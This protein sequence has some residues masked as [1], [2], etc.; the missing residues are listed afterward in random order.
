VEVF[1]VGFDSKLI[2]G[3]NK[4]RKFIMSFLEKVVVVWELAE[5]REQF[6]KPEEGERQ[7]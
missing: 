1:Y 3:D 4:T 5:A 7:Q 2:T 6:G